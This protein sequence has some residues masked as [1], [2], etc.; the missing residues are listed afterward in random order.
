MKSRIP[1]LLTAGALAALAF[2]V[3]LGAAKGTAKKAAPPP[4]KMPALKVDNSPLGEGGQPGRLTSYADVLDAVRPAVAP[5]SRG[6]IQVRPLPASLIQRWRLGA[7]K[8]VWPCCIP[9]RLMA[10][11]P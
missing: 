10:G 8:L 2:T 6:S 7:T 5:I 1:S 9:W 11:N 4:G 3:W